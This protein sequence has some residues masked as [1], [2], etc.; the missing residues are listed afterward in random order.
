MKAADFDEALLREWRDFVTDPNARDAFD[1]LVSHA[2]GVPGYDCRPVKQGYLKSFY[3]EQPGKRPF[4]LVVNRNSILFY[5]RKPGMQQF[6][7][8]SDKFK[9]I[10]ADVTLTRLG[11]LQIRVNNAEDA[12]HLI[13]LLF[14]EPQSAL[15]HFEVGSLYRRRDD[16]HGPF[17]GQQ[18]GG[19]S[20]P[21][22]QPYIFLFT[23]SSGE[24]HGYRDGWKDGVFH[25][26]GEGQLGDMTFA[27]GNRAIRDHVEE[28]KDLFLFETQG[29]GKPVQYLGRFACVSWEENRGPDREGRERN[30]IV[31]HLLSAE[32]EGGA[33]L[34]DAVETSPGVVDLASLRMRAY[35]AAT[36]AAKGVTRDAR[37]TYYQRSRDVANYVLARANGTCESCRQAAPFRRKDGRPYLEPHHTRRVSD[38]GPDH[39]RWVGAVCPN[40]HREIHSGAQ[41]ME[42]NSQLEADL[43]S[44]EP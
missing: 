44:L 3:Y 39:P 20:T 15:P 41:G 4:A 36:P 26:S 14:G 10:F 30:V 35:E 6:P 43:G 27:A 23:G 19:I 37:Q 12:R 11:E 16:I 25:Y 17:G 24:Q 22:D 40:C 38:A 7:R 13:S 42:R 18:Q 34:L 2:A 33:V 28:G 9:E 21:R 31:F 29:H 8:G 5:V 1:T 32:D